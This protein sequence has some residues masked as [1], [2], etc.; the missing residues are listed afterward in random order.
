[1]S[2]VAHSLIDEAMKK[3][4]IAWVA[5]GGGAG[6]GLDG[7]PARC[8]WC[9]P[10]D[11]ALWV[12]TGPGEQELPGLA[13]ADR[14][15]V[16]LRGGHGGRVVTWPAS[17]TRLEPG[18]DEWDEIAP[19]LAGKRLNATGDVAALTARWA[20][21]CTVHRLDPAGDPVEAGAT[22]PDAALAAPPRETP[23]RRRTRAPFRLHRVR[24]NR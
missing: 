4:A 20:A 16:T 6:G 13:T 9:M 19:Q 14:V 10:A 12:V 15:L 3:A 11:G 8:V 2:D 7:G 22:L 5:V 1:M 21:E 18:S 24:R 17:V 23:A